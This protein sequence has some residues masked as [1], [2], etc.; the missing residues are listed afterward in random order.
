MRNR[1]HNETKNVLLYEEKN[2]V[3]ILTLNRP[4]QHNALS[5]SLL[6]NLDLILE[7]IK[8]DKNIKSVVI[9]GKGPSFCSGHDLKEMRQTTDKNEHKSLNILVSH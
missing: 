2:R 1:M 8:N 4:E 7:N 3:A 5:K 6:N 9:F